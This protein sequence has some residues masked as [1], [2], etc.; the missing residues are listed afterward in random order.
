MELHP[1]QR[2]AAPFLPAPAEVDTF[3]PRR[4]PSPSLPLTRSAAVRAV[5]DQRDAVDV[6]IQESA[7]K[8]LDY[9]LRQKASAAMD[10]ALLEER[11][12]APK[13]EIRLERNLYVD[14]PRILGAAVVIPLPAP[15]PEPAFTY[16]DP[17][18]GNAAVQERARERDEDGYQSGAMQRDDEVE[19]VGMAMDYER[20]SG[21]RPEDVS[22]E[23][24]GFD[25]RSIRCNADG[26]YGGI[27]YIEVKGRA[28]AG[29][30]VIR[31]AA[32][33]CTWT[34]MPPPRRC[35]LPCSRRVRKRAC[36]WRSS[37]FSS[38]GL[39]CHS[40]G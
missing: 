7:Q 11:R 32:R 37:R 20:E 5:L 13:R 26:T 30:W 2:I 31:R 29:A 1:G 15:E 21:W 27:R 23:N 35:K 12:A 25:I 24:L 39:T 33:A 19:A 34:R 36:A 40:P 10:L 22:R 9:R 14:A 17:A 8:I 3:M 28:G 6:R 4:S 16:P 38:T 18:G